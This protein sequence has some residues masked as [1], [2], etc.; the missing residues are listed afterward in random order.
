MVDVV[1]A[2]VVGTVA[3]I[4]IF[5]VA[6]TYYANVYGFLQ[7]EVEANKLE[8]IADHVAS[9]IVDL[10]SLSYLVTGD[11]ILNKT[12]TLPKG[13]GDDIYTV[14][15]L[16]FSDPVTGEILYA[17]RAYLTLNP[18]VYRDSELPWTSGGRLTVD[19]TASSISGGVENTIV[20]CRKTG[21][22]IKIGFAIGG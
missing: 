17:V 11:N 6:G 1:I 7:A 14:N 19:P 9:N 22:N 20:W 10:V 2:H 21:D 16:N 5:F 18:S 4:V 8:E 3:L 15:V 12:I 13:V